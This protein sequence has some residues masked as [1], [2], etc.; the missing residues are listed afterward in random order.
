M[1]HCLSFLTRVSKLFNDWILLD[2]KWIIWLWLETILLLLI[3]A[4]FIHKITMKN[5]LDNIL[6]S[7]ICESRGVFLLFVCCSQMSLINCEKI[8]HGCYSIFLSFCI[9]HIYWFNSL[10]TP[11]MWRKTLQVFYIHYTHNISLGKVIK[12]TMGQNGIRLQGFILIAT[13]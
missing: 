3:R 11:K 13:T 6:P 8:C 10:Y 5:Q 2:I 1:K 7:Y 4:W 9:K 12:L